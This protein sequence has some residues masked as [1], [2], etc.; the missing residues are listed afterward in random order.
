MG[1]LHAIH[2]DGQ[3]LRVDRRRRRERP[4]LPRGVHGGLLLSLGHRA[5]PFRV[6]PRRFVGDR[7]PQRLP[8][9]VHG[10]LKR[11]FD[12]QA[13][14][15]PQERRRERP[16]TEP[17][18]H[19]E[20][21]LPASARV[22]QVVGPAD[23]VVAHDALNVPGARQ[24]H[25]PHRPATVRAGQPFDSLARRPSRQHPFHHL[26]QDCPPYRLQ[27]PFQARQIIRAHLRR[28]RLQRRLEQHPH[29]VYAVLGQVYSVHRYPPQA[30]S[31]RLPRP[32]PLG[33]Y[34]FSRPL[35]FLGYTHEPLLP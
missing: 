21:R 26:P 25:A 32:C 22:A 11:R 16:R 23:G 2:R 6:P 4:P 29:L 34:R 17:D 13:A 8:R 27:P 33:G 28:R 1:R 9:R 3:H 7:H 5:D 10:L 24:V 18:A 14:H 19:V 35:T 15:R 20:G 12:T 31:G 30:R